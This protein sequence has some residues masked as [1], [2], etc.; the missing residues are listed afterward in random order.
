MKRISQCIING[1][2][3]DN[4]ITMVHMSLLAATIHLKK[5]AEEHS[6]SENR[7]SD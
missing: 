6:Q 2:D 1:T 3:Q 5:T 7:T 4:V